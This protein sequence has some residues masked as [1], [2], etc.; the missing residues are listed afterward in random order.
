MNTL[1]FLLHQTF[2]LQVYWESR[3]IVL[4]LSKSM[5]DNII[6]LFS[7]FVRNSRRNIGMIPPSVKQG[8]VTIYLYLF[9]YM[10]INVKTCN[11]MA[12]KLYWNMIR[13]KVKVGFSFIME[14]ASTEANFKT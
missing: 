6:K 2:C 3:N 1:K 11:R 9:Y 14:N 5:M 13:F 10:N 4:N 8:N 12:R 7:L